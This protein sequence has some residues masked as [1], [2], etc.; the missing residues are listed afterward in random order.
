MEL[1]TIFANRAEFEKSIRLLGCLKEP[2]Q[3]ICAG[4]SVHNT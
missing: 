4:L 3:E 1:V 2:L